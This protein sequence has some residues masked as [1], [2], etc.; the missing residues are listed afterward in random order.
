M[1]GAAT[2]LWVIAGIYG[3]ALVL[4]LVHWFTQGIRFIER[5]RRRDLPRVR[6]RINL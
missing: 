6:T 4:F 5:E 2:L 1:S 3:T